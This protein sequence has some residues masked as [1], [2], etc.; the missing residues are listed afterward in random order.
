MTHKEKLHQAADLLRKV[1]GRAT[2][3]PWALIEGFRGGHDVIVSTSLSVDGRDAEVLEVQHYSQ[4]PDARWITLVHPGLAGPLADLLEHVADRHFPE[5]SQTLWDQRDGLWCTVDD[6]R[7][8]CPDVQKALAVA[9][10]ILHE[11]E[12][13][14]EE[15]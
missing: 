2:P 14:E 8:P 3:G 5:K 13:W 10:L 9:E 15:Q 11:K 6:H 7:W 1:T 4:R 12:D